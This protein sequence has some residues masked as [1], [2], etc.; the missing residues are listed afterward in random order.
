[1][2]FFL[3]LL[4][5]PLGLATRFWNQSMPQVV[6]LYGGDVLSATC[7]FFGVRFLA[8]RRSLFWVTVVSFIVCILVECLQL[9]K[10][11]WILELRRT[12]VGGILMGHGFLWSDLVCYAVG[13]L[14]GLLIA[15]FAE[16]L[17]T[18]RGT[19]SP[20]SRKQRYFISHH[21]E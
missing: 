12:R 8:V 2:Y 18:G 16:R 4:T 6:Q 21:K 9:Y 10:A 5:I 3:V 14:I 19:K 7:I 1:L 13:V 11:P 20:Y 17:I 15:Y